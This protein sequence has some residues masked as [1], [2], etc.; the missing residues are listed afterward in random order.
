MPHTQKLST[1]ITLMGVTMVTTT[2]R[3][4][5][6]PTASAGFWVANYTEERKQ[7]WDAFVATASNATF[8]FCRDY[9]DYHRERFADHSLMVFHGTEL[10]A[11][12]PANLRSDNVVVSHEGL[13]YG[14]L[15]VRPDVKLE[16]VLACLYWALRHLV[17]EGIA[18]L[19]YKRIPSFYALRP[20]DDVAYGLFLLQAL[21]CRRDCAQVIPLPASL[22]F[23]KRRKRRINKAR[24]FGL[25]LVQESRFLPFWE[26]VLEPRLASRYGVKPVHSAREISQLAAH[27][28]QSIKQFSVYD[29][30]GILAGVTIYETSTVAHTQYIAASDAGRAIGA[31]DFLLDWLIHDRYQDKKFFDLGICNENDGRALNFGL[32]EWKESFG[33]RTFSHEF[34]EVSTLAFARLEPALRPPDRLRNGADQSH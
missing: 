20:D 7:Q 24:A 26:Q 30:L 8:L 6:A 1:A 12:L 5:T 32:L 10:K 33:A 29:G 22:P 31:L 18:S 15:V 16:D 2:P 11:V 17:E 34:Y 23:Q 13:T 21:L 14:G 25:H 4:A 19:I 27:F 3:W 28:P 9:M